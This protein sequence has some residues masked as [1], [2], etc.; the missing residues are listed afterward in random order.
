MYS[1][2][3]TLTTPS[4]QKFL[5]QEHDQCITE[6]NASILYWNHSPLHQ[7]CLP[8]PPG[9]IHLGDYQHFWLTHRILWY[10]PNTFSSIVGILKPNPDQNAWSDNNQWCILAL[11]WLTLSKSTILL[12][13]DFQNISPTIIKDV[14][15]TLIYRPISHLFT[16][17]TYG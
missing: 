15:P 6:K 10:F 5:S 9:S 11:L 1:V 4:L 14:P 2:H 7:W 13:N 16:I 12:D 3:A 17:P 8:V